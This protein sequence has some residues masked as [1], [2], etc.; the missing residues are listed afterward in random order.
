[1]WIGIAISKAFESGTLGSWRDDLELLLGQP[2]LAELLEK[3]IFDHCSEVVNV[4]L[5]G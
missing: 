2:G 3:K 1:M 5:G 4:I